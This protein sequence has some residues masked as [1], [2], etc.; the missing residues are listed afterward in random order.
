MKERVKDFLM[1]WL[2]EAPMCFLEDHPLLTSVLASLVGALAANYI[3]YRF[4]R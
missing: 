2:W 4:L 3:I 1:E